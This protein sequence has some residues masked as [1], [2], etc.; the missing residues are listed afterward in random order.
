MEQERN[1]EKKCSI[2]KRIKYYAESQEKL[3]AHLLDYMQ[4]HP[5]LTPEPPSPPP[6]EFQKIMAELDKRGSRTVVRRQ[7]RTLHYGHRLVNFLQKP[8]MIIMVLLV[9][10]TV[11]SIGMS[12]R[13]AYDY[14]MRVRKAGEIGIIW[15]NNPYVPV[16]VEKISDAYEVIKENLDIKPLMIDEMPLEMGFYG[17]DIEGG[18]AT[19]KFSYNGQ[20]VYFIQAKN[21]ISS[22][23]NIISGKAVFKSVYNG[24]IDKDFNIEKNDLPDG[25]AEYSTGIVMNGAYYY[26]SAIMPEQDFEAIV[27]KLHY[28]ED[29]K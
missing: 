11:S 5:E 18:S 29:D 2:L 19:I 26:L 24:I 20:D 15:N 7:L 16:K 10:I 14:R 12:A 6:G 4:K 25:T 13:K 21:L 8:L 9:I 28:Y 1:R 23:I 17:M 27:K 22:S 3:E